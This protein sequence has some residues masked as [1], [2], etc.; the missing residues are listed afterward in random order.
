MAISKAPLALLSL[1]L[2]AGLANANTT[3]INVNEANA[4]ALQTLSGVG[5]AT[6]EAIV[7]DRQANGPYERVESLTRVNGIGDA[8]LESLKE[9]V[10]IE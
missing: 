3:A 8:T 2:T 9:Q 4:A 7:E 10:A 1:A 6:A 5:P